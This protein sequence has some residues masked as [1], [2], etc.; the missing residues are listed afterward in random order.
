VGKLD[1]A[2]KV[3]YQLCNSVYMLC[4]VLCLTSYLF[5]FGLLRGESQHLTQS[6]VEFMA[7]CSKIGNLTVYKQSSVKDLGRV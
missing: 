4:F 5:Y 2:L 7:P 3:F 6:S 1:N